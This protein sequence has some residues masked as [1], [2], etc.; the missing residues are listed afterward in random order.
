MRFV[1]NR[2]LGAARDLPQDSLESLHAAEKLGGQSDLLGEE[3]DEASFAQSNLI[4]HAGDRAIGKPAEIAD[5]EAYGRVRRIRRLGNPAEQRAL[6]NI[7][8]WFRRFG[9]E[10]SFAQA[11]ASA[12]QSAS[13]ETSVSCNSSAGSLKNGKRAARL[14]DRAHG[15]ALLGGIDHGESEYAPTRMAPLSVLHLLGS[16]GS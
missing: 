16:L 12:P 15:G 9:V 4:R 2:W 3:L 10:Q 5:G 11:A 7:E 8:F 1:S 14:E 6:Q 13:S